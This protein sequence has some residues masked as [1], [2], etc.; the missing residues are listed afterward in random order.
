MYKRASRYIQHRSTSRI[1][2]LAQT[3]T[4]RNRNY[5]SYDLNRVRAAEKSGE[6]LVGR[7][8]NVTSQGA[9][10]ALGSV[11]GLVRMSE[12][13]DHRVHIYNIN[14][15]V[16][17]GMSV[18]VVVLHVDEHGKRISL[19]MRRVPKADPPAAGL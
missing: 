18:R 14:K 4:K 9:F 10:I 17:Q 15:V 1:G 3:G 6:I 13:A 12:I 2:E 8:K 7:V 5:R 19:S 16:R 11:D